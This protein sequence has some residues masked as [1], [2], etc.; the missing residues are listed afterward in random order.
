MNEPEEIPPERAW[1]ERESETIRAIVRRVLKADHVRAQAKLA[2]VERVWREA[3]G[4]LGAEALG[5]ETYVRGLRNGVLHIAV[6]SPAAL[7]EIAGYYE[8]EAVAALRALLP[9]QG[10]RR[11]KYAVL[12]PRT[13]FQDGTGT[14]GADERGSEHHRPDD[15]VL[16]ADDSSETT[17]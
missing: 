13:P 14:G 6:A 2:D 12:P 4:A 9:A 5:R 11:V 16:E 8:K 1:P 17:P 7:C 10:V 3:I 15:A